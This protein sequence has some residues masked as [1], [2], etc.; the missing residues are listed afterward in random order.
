[1]RL[2][3]TDWNGSSQEAT[4]SAAEKVFVVVAAGLGV[5]FAVA[6]AVMCATRTWNVDAGG[7]PLIN[8]FV[9]FWSAG[10]LA[11]HGHAVAAYDPQLRHAAEIAT[12]GH[13]FPD[14]IGWWYPPL[15]LFVAVALASVP[16]A[17]A[18]NLMNVLTLLLHASA[19]G[20]IARR[21]AAFVLVAAPPWAMLG[22][23]HG[24]TQFLTASIIGVVLV[25]LE[26]YPAVSGVLLGLLTYK[27]QLGLLFPVALAFGGYWRAF[28]WACVGTVLWTAFSGAVFGF[29]SLLAFVRSLA[30]VGHRVLETNPDYLSNLQSVYGVARNFGV[31]E[32][33]AWIVQLLSTAVAVLV[34]ARLW[35]SDVPLDLKAAGLAVAIPLT[36]PYF[37]VYD[38]ILLSV[39]LSFLFRHR[40]FD[41]TE[42]L[43]VIVALICGGYF[44]AFGPQSLH[45]TGLVSCAAIATIVWRRVQECHAAEAAGA[46]Q[47]ELA[48]SGAAG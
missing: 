45:F 9:S 17:M 26:E 5:G 18:F 41:R 13:D 34:V 23:I 14:L 19:T 42:W 27:P 22:M 11:L 40:R 1:V 43:A 37:W 7:H 39:A 48:M 15:F 2:L 36:T 6:L 29:D 20:F 31:P 10:K 32:H 4:A 8:D 46:S 16:Y 25:T 35:R 24:Q 38:L 3:G 44:V 47:S 12:V 28:A 30:V 21:R 33:L